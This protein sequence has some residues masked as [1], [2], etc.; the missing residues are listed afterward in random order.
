[1]QCPDENSFALTLFDSSGIGPNCVRFYIISNES[2]L[3]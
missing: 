1:M 3:I 2:G